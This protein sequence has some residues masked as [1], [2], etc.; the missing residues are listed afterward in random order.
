M[1]AILKMLLY[2][3]LV[4]GLVA[5][6]YANAEQRVDVTY[7]PGR[8]VGDVPVFLV[9]LAS[10]FVGV[11]IAGVVAV[12]E[13]FR[14]NMREREMQRRIDELDAEVRELRTPPV[15]DPIEDDAGT[16]DWPEQ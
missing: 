10:V 14:H 11:A 9:I 8:T 6:A 4:I 7:F 1:N 5:I 16:A 15:G 13:H 3:A 12:F 2:L